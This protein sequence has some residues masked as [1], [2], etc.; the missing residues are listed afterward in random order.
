M[1]ITYDD[2]KKD[3]PCEQLQKL[4]MSA[5]WSNGSRTSEMNKP[6]INST[7]VISAWESE[8]LIG[9]VRVLSDKIIRSI[10]YDLIVDPEFQNRG[11]G[12]ELVKR[13]IEHFPDSEWVVGTLRDISKFYEEI[14]FQKD[15]NSGSVYLSIPSKYQCPKQAKLIIRPPHE[16]HSNKYF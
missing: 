16:L 15:D 10:I 13:C 1:S 2:T 6:F 3:L 8:R 11:I 14:G 7:L 5:G 12:K 4:F 9:A